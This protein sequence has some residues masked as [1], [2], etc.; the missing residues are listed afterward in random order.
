MKHAGLFGALMDIYNL[1]L[2]N[3]DSKAKNGGHVAGAGARVFKKVDM[4]AKH[5][6]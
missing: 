2:L 3:S 6:R 1:K 5:T 4:I